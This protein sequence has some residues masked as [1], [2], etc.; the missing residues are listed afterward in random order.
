MDTLIKIGVFS[1]ICCVLLAVI[2]KTFNK[3]LKLN[4]RLHLKFLRSTLSVVVIIICVYSCLSQFEVTKDVSKTLLQS[5][6]LII[7]IATFAAQQAL[8]NIISGF[9]ISLARPFDVGQKVKVMSGSSVIAE[10]I[11]SD[12]TIRHT[13]IKQFDGQ[14]CI[15][16]NSTMDS[17]VVINTNYTENVGNFFEIEIS[18]DS[19]IDKAIEIMSKVCIEEPLSINT[20][21]NKV[22]INKLSTNGV[23]LKTTIWTNTL[24]DNFQACSNIRRK[25]LEEFEKENIKI[26][27]NTY[28][29][30]KEN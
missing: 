12:I 24:D 10:G 27:F 5:G 11:I 8:G 19:D 22:L 17:C 23:V 15:V 3:I 9:S 30:I 2:Q 26:P 6:S 16:P 14:S 25:L 21:K 20:E 28:S 13:V 4:N 1:V 18:F 7:A 29:I